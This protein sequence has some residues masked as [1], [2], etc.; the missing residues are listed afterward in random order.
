MNPN[1]D[2]SVVGIFG[3]LAGDDRYGILFGVEPKLRMFEVAPRDRDKEE[4]AQ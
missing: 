4:P 3:F 2:L 1:L